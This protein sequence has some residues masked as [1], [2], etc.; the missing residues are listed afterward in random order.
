MN[1]L[2]KMGLIASLI[3]PTVLSIHTIK[4]FSNNADGSQTQQPAQTAIASPIETKI[5]ATSTPPAETEKSFVNLYMEAGKKFGAAD[6]EGAVKLYNESLEYVKYGLQKA[7]IY[8]KLVD[9]YHALG[10]LEMELKYAELVPKYSANPRVNEKYEHRAEE[11]KKLLNAK[12]PT[13]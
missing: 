8:Y 4:S 9:A 11:I 7:M 5:N 1:K 10:N 6:Y 13:S 2:I 3:V 12:T